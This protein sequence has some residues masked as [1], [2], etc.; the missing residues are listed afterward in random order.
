M[1]GLSKPAGA[2][3]RRGCSRRR[4]GQ[5]GWKFQPP[6]PRPR[7]RR[8]STERFAGGGDS[9]AGALLGTATSPGSPRAPRCASL[10]LGLGRVTLERL[11]WRG[12]WGGCPGDSSV[13]RGQ[14]A[15]LGDSSIPWGQQHPPGAWL[16][17]PS[18]GT[19]MHAALWGSPS[20][21]DPPLFGHPLG[22]NKRELA[23]SSA[24]GPGWSRGSSS[25]ERNQQG[26]KKK[27][28]KASSASHGSSRRRGF[29]PAEQDGALGASPSPAGAGAQRRMLLT[30]GLPKWFL[31]LRRGRQYLARGSKQMEV[32]G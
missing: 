16:S 15:S 19:P 4:W 31:F 20:L 26:K 1:E 10:R 30:Q 25:T 32:S 8:G 24:T 18:F 12:C 17:A 14:R 5:K 29:P 27:T 21:W 2:A 28:P 6:P 11:S 9:A 7:A 13:P 22:L 23:V 3:H